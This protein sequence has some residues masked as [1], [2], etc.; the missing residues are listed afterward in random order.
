MWS[1]KPYV[2]INTLKMIYCS[3]FNS[4]FIY[5]LLFWGHSSDS[6]KIFRLQKNIIKIIMCCRSGCCRK[7]FFNLEILPLPSQGSWLRHC[8]TSQK[9]V[10][11]ISD[12]VIGIFH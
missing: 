10:G 12:G 2:S 1:V 9:V 3:Y 11:S 6:I 7:L 5:G 4:V 8:S